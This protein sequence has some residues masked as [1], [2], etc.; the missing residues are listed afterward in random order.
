MRVVQ[1]TGF[2]NWLHR[3][4]HPSPC[5]TTCT[6]ISEREGA[7]NQENVGY[8]SVGGS[9][10]VESAC[11]C[12]VHA[13]SLPSGCAA[14]CVFFRLCMAK[15]PPTRQ[16]RIRTTPPPMISVVLLSPPLS[17]VPIVLSSGSVVHNSALIHGVEL[18]HDRARSHP[19]VPR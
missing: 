18:G 4:V 14:T 19:S 9:A 12:S 13:G 8:C 5:M 16:M 17:V 1:R 15:Y 10:A 11:V 2:S 3:Q 6:A 7:M